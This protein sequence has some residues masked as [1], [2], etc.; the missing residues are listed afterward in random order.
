MTDGRQF[1]EVFLS[2]S[3]KDVGLVRKVGLIIRAVGVKPW[4]DEQSIDP[5]ELWRVSIATSIEHC[6]RM[7]VF[8]CRHS[9]SSDEVQREYELAIEKKKLIVPIRLDRSRMS[10]KLSPYQEIDVRRLMWWSH[11]VIRWERILLIIGAALLLIGVIYA[12]I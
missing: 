11:E 2:Y 5:G 7:L 12:R 8:W 6:E 1:S 10:S 9:E 4:R 3:R